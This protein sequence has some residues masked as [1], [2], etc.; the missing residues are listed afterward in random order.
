[1]C[2]CATGVKYHDARKAIGLPEGRDLPDVIDLTIY[3]A[4]APGDPAIGQVDARGRRLGPVRATYKWHGCIMLV[5]WLLCA[6]IAILLAR[7]Y[8]WTL[9][10]ANLLLGSKLW[11]QVSLRVRLPLQAAQYYTNGLLV[12]SLQR[13]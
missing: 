3:R 10:F 9:P 1:M 2:V 5:A 11:F 12:H 13:I 6:P 8:R 7:Y 4:P